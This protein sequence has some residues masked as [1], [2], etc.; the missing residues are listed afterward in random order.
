MFFAEDWGWDIAEDW[1]SFS[2]DDEAEADDHIT[3]ALLAAKRVI[4]HLLR[5]GDLK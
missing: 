2:T 1:F 4:Y 5:E 3:F